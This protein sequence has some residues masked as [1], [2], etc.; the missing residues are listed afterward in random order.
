MLLAIVLFKLKPPEGLS[1]SQKYQSK[2][3]REYSQLSL[4][5]SVPL[6]RLRSYSFFEIDVFC[7][8]GNVRP[9]LPQ[10]V[11]CDNMS[12]CMEFV[13]P[14]P[15]AKDLYPIHEVAKN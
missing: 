12:I 7:M 4:L 3:C 13:A 9:L 2:K 15:P 8:I 1:F 5:D 11:L 6:E 10:I 14:K